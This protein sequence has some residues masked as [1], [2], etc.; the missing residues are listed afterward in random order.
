VWLDKEFKD[1]IKKRDNYECQNKYC[2]GKSKRLV[3]H[4]IDYNKKNCSTDNLIT[5]CNS[6]NS[7]ANAN[8]G[9]HKEYYGKII[10]DR[11]D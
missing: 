8:R 3:V 6:C 5:L 7:R 10:I 1:S 4:H 2:C 9:W 11:G